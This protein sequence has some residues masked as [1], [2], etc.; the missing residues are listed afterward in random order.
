MKTK[1]KTNSNGHR[2]LSPSRKWRGIFIALPA[3]YVLNVIL[4][5]LSTQMPALYNRQMYSL[6]EGQIAE[7][8]IVADRELLYTDAERT[9]Q[10]REDAAAKIL[11]VY[12]IDE[13]I[14]LKQLENFERFAAFFAEEGRNMEEQRLQEELSFR[15]P[16]IFSRE[17]LKYI[18]ETRKVA[19]FMPLLEEVLRDLLEGGI[20]PSK[21]VTNEN[22]S[23]FI[24]ELRHWQ[25]NKKVHEPLT[26]NQIVSIDG[27]HGQI[28][29][30]V[31]GLEMDTDVR[32]L[33]VLL[34]SKFAVQNAYY[35]PNITAALREEAVS[36]VRPVV[37][38]IRQGQTIVRKGDMVSAEDVQMI[39]A[40]MDQRPKAD[41][42]ESIAI[43]IYM[44][45]FFF[46]SY[47]MFAP[48]IAGRPRTLQYSYILM[49]ASVLFT[50]NIFIVLAFSLVP[51]GVPVSLGIFTA[52]ISM[53]VATLVSQRVGLISSL[54]LSLIFF[55]VPDIDIYTFVFSFLSGITATYLIRNAERRIDLVTGTIKLTGIVVFIV[56]TI[57]LFQQKDGGWYLFAGGLAIIHALVTG[58]MNLALLPA[59]EHLL[60]APT[61]FRLRE[62]SDTNT[63]IFKRMIMVAP[64]TYSHSMSVANLAESA[65][66]EIGANH[67]LAR[68]GAYY[69][70]I[71]KMDQPDYFIENQQEKNKHDELTPS[72]SVAV[73]KSHVKIGKEKAKELKLPPEIVEIVADH[74]GSDIIGYFYQQ[75]VKQ[76]KEKVVPSDFSY[77]GSPPRSKEATV[78][79]L[80]DSVEA[81]SRTIKKP[82][83]QKFE[84]MIWDTM[85]SKINRHQ[86]SNSVLSFQEIEKIK[87][88][89]V[90]IL[91]GQFHNRIE[92]P[93]QKV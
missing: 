13:I 84:K 35:D 59:L 31:S 73:I 16:N 68:V 64:G 20:F 53:L 37:E 38:T 48:L 81:Q 33:A 86:L 29:K 41:I 2:H 80:A 93:V 85:M 87:N 62:L 43:V 18:A 25:E 26:R 71:G 52:L 49:A 70:D 46:L 61:V 58:A 60:N 40:L 34:L 74:H 91:A 32:D 1:K 11:P 63:P 76:G 12:E 22:E 57:G 55:A 82:T 51:V 56:I 45:G 6:Q 89:F 54:L 15:F 21:L 8:D 77:N 79:M 44:A 10:R 28:R 65:C 27:I 9:S 17:D 4:L 72:L 67:L 90:Q 83:V 42:R 78:V 39:R 23:G 69:H 50:L 75:A 5:I 92:Y 19:D 47:I 88:S 14:V 24:L 30:M 66:K 36:R 7:S 3:A